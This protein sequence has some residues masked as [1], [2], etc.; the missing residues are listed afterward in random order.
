MRRDGHQGSVSTQMN[1]WPLTLTQIL[2]WRLP[3][4][5]G[6]PGN[7]RQYQFPDPDAVECRRVA[8]A[9]GLA[10]SPKGGNNARERWVVSK[11]ERRRAGWLASN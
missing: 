8:L 10:R 11:R 5:D 4:I 2:E 1:R 6:F 7:W 9:E 3:P